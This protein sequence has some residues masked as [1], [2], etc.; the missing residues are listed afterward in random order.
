MR[1]S[2]PEI[3]LD[4]IPV[5]EGVGRYRLAYPLATGGMATVYVAFADDAT[6]PRDAVAL[7]Y[8]H[9]HLAS[10]RAFVEMFLD[11]ARLAARIEHPNV[12][13]VFEL[14]AAGG[15]HYLTMELLLGR[16]LSR[17]AKRLRRLPPEAR[18]PLAMHVVMRAAEGL[19]AAHELCDASGASLEVVHRDV[20]PHNVIVTYDGA[21][22]VIDFG[23]AR[24][25]GRL[26]HTE[27]GTVKGKF[28]YMAPEQMLG[29]RVDRRADVFSLGVILYELLTGSKLFKRATE[30]ETVLA[31]TAHRGL[32]ERTLP[33]GLSPGLVRVLAGALA[34]EPDART[35]SAGALAAGL[36][37][38]LAAYAP[39][40][41]EGA[42]HALFPGAAE[43][44]EGRV[45]DAFVDGLARFGQDGPDPERSSIVRRSS[46]PPP[47]GR[48]LAVLATVLTL[49]ALAGGAYALH[50][51]PW[52]AT[53][54]GP[55]ALAEPPPEP[56]A[57]VEVEPPAPAPEEVAPEV[58]EPAAEALV[59]EAPARR[60]A[61]RRAA[62]AGGAGTVNVATSGGW[63]EVYLDGRRLGT[64]P[65]RFVV[66][67]GRHTLVVRP[68]GGTEVRRV[69][70]EVAAGETARVRV[71]LP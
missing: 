71:E 31:V 15:A 34:P 51:A 8:V 4:E 42:M 38:E 37:R 9:P 19:H 32:D 60:R 53:S 66:P 27:T 49:G 28:S 70:V 11:E 24:A 36:A 20:S 14:G 58:E 5:P 61:S 64:T 17:V 16:P 3:V 13:R 18:V 47:R 65:G 69:P 63:A 55:A 30:T 1:A 29:A 35:P 57:A 33:E 6:S 67:A 54:P 50:A 25:R 10:Q 46:A 26:H 48:G 62:L 12:A 21:V 43:D 7:K 68:H 2:E 45:R 56:A 59:A 22:K 23:I 39:V 52:R 40:D 41:L 44:A